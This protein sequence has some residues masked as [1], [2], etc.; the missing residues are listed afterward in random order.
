MNDPATITWGLLSH[1]NAGKT[2]LARTLL[3]RDI[4]EI[5]D[6]AHVTEHSERHTLI[7]SPEGDAL[8]LWDTPGFGDS[9]RLS[10]RLKQQAD[11]ITWV[12][13]QSW[14]RF[15]DRPYWSGQQ[16]IRTAHVDCDIVL[17]VVNA[18]ETP[19]DAP[20]VATELEILERIGKPVLLLLNQAGPQRTAARAQSEAELWRAHL[21]TYRCVRGVVAFDAFARCWVQEGTLVDQLAKLVRPEQQPAAARLSAAWHARNLEVFERSI[22]VLAS[23]LALT[24]ADE[25]P[26]A[27]TDLPQRVRQWVGA[28]TTQGEH[29]DRELERAHE[30]LASRVDDVD[31]GAVDSLIQLH[32]L[33]GHAAAEP[34]RMLA[35]DLAVER[36]IDAHRA[37]LVGGFVAGAAGGVAADL[38]VGGLSFGSGALIGAIVGALG[39]RGATRAYNVARGREQGR[40]RWSPPWLTQRLGNALIG[41][42]AVAHFGR[43]RGEFVRAAIPDTWQQALSALALHRDTLDAIWKRAATSDRAAIEQQL[44]APLRELARTVLVGLYPEAEPATQAPLPNKNVVSDR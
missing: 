26:L 4:G 14:D 38:A 28:L 30:A 17:Y 41:Y 24:A 32:G 29:T 36:P 19:E 12:L 16:A 11:P 37:S 7:E 35:Q 10:K 43:G 6:R 5:G 8:V 13:A 23:Q 34:L 27:L 3:R 18:A 20:F 40:V 21:A 15:A 2:T 33:S 25:E 31:R 22:Q 39:A 1:T 44:R 42:L 9:M